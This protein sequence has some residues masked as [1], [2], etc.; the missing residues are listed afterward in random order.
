MWY[1]LKHLILK[2][3]FRSNVDVCALV[4]G[5]VTVLG[6]REDGDTATIVFD[7]VP[8]HADLM[9][10]NDGLE[11][12]VLAEALRDIWSE[13][14][15]DTAL[16]RT[17]ARLWLWVGPEHLHHQALLAWLSL[18]VAVELPDIVERCL[19]IGEKTAMKNKILVGD[20]SGKRQG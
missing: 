1:G 10:S 15:P 11:A 5:C 12:I 7:L 8:L 3:Q 9:R 2:L 6:R 18:S 16:A 13:L 20:Q 14:H 4:L 17:T 19:I